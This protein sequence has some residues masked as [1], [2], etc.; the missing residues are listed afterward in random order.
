MKN[1]LQYIVRAAASLFHRI[2]AIFV[3]HKT[4]EAS[5]HPPEPP[6]LTRAE[7][8]AIWRGT[9]GRPG[10]KINRLFAQKRATIR[11]ITHAY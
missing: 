8:K 7:L 1:P 11:Q 3:Q 2:K 5:A 10:D 6:I 4:I 9:H